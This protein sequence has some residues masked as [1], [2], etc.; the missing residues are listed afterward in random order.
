M[1]IAVL[2]CLCVFV[3]FRFCRL[4]K[5]LP[6]TGSNLPLVFVTRALFSFL[7]A[8]LHLSKQ[9]T[10]SCGPAAAGPVPLPLAP[11]TAS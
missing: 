11:P 9:P 1:R 8:F 4:I 2:C 6:F 3:F 5:Y 7:T 10:G